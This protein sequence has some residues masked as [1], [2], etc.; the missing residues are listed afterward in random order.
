M[1][2]W[3]LSF[4]LEKARGGFRGATVVEARDEMSALAT[5]TMRGLNPGGEV[6]ILEVLPEEE[7]EPDIRQMLNRLVRREEMDAMGGRRHGDLPQ[8]IQDA[9]EHEARF[10]C[11]ECNHPGDGCTCH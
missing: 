9:F 3:Y 8:Y 6:A 4:A 10:I 5:A 11:E 2:Y 7:D 1:T